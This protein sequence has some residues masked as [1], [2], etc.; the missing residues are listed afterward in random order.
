MMVM[1][2][3]VITLFVVEREGVV[4]GGGDFHFLCPESKKH[5]ERKSRVLTSWAIK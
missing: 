1:K 4:G 3:D 2:I 5:D